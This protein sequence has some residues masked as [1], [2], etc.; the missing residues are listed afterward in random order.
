[1]A[2]RVPSGPTRTMVRQQAL[3]RLESFRHGKR[4]DGLRQLHDEGCRR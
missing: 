1:M 2:R 4:L 3:A